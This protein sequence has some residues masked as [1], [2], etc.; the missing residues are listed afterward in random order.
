VGSSK[1]G[2]R[3]VSFSKERGSFYYL[4]ALYDGVCPL[5]QDKA[6]CAVLPRNISL[7][8]LRKFYFLRKMAA[9][10]DPLPGRKALVLYGSETG[11]AQDVAEEL[12]RMVQR[13]RFSS[14]VSEMN[15]VNLVRAP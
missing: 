10:Q 11:S 1:K 4:S 13:L 12:G 14:Q 8:T 5:N 2:E 9:S 15:A 3:G 7:S 6:C